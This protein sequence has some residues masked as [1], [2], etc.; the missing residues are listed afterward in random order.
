MKK[1]PTTTAAPTA[2]A[3]TPAATSTG[4]PA[5]AAAAPSSGTSNNIR[6]MNF[7]VTGNDLQMRIRVLQARGLKGS[8]ADKISTV[9]KV[10]FA[11]F[12]LKDSPVVADT[13][14]PQYNF[15][16]NLSLVVEEVEFQKFWFRSIS[17]EFTR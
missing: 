8:K 15:E 1:T 17:F 9:A 14:N 6:D 7:H 5:A 4:T 11:D 10:Q 16:Q 12:V 13:V 3:P 2:T